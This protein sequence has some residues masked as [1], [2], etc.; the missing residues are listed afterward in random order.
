VRNRPEF[1]RSREKNREF[2]SLLAKTLKF[3]PKLADLALEQGIC[4]DLAGNYADLSQHHINN[5]FS[6]RQGCKQELSREFAGNLRSCLR[7]LVSAVQA[8]RLAFS[9][10]RERNSISPALVHF[11]PLRLLFDKRQ[12]LLAHIMHADPSPVD[13]RR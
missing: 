4:R 7:D 5:G 3:C 2:F 11:S 10:E 1:S 13:E 12:A 6:L 9:A 8:Q